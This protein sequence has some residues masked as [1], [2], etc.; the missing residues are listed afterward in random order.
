MIEYRGVEIIV[1]ICRPLI[2][3]VMLSANQVQVSKV[4][5]D[6]WLRNNCYCLR[7]ILFVEVSN[8]QDRSLSHPPL[9]GQ[10]NA[11]SSEVNC[12]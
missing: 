8:F 9:P 5:P 12:M 1:D 2:H 7:V 6:S 10:Q 3:Q 4:P 11:E